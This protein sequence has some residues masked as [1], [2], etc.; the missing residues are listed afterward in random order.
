SR[1]ASSAGP[2]VPYPRPYSSSTVWIGVL[3]AATRPLT[4]PRSPTRTS[5]VASVPNALT[6]HRPAPAPVPSAALVHSAAAVVMPRT[7]PRSRMMAPA[8][9]KPIPEAT[10]AA[11]RIGSTFGPRSMSENP[12]APA[13][14]NTAAPPATSACVPQPAGLLRVSRSSPITAPKITAPRSRRATSSGP[15][16]G[17]HRRARARLCSSRTSMPSAAGGPRAATP[18]RSERWRVAR[19]ATPA[20]ERSFAHTPARRWAAVASSGEKAGRD[21]RFRR[22][23]HGALDR[24][25][26]QLGAAAKAWRQ[27]DTREVV[28]DGARQDVELR[29]D[30]AVGVAVRHEPQDV[31]LARHEKRSTTD[32]HAARDVRVLAQ[33]VAGERGSD[34][35][36]TAVDR[37]HCLSQLASADAL[38]P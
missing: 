29:S 15:T 19:R 12:Y 34:D 36:A 28:L 8:P 10:C 32:A 38:G 9:M 17:R 35:R 25:P 4:A 3:R 24:P 18:G 33:Q 20:A 6:H 1:T 14:V 13:I 7:E 22:S 2:S 27:A 31:L 23:G 16:K 5:S 11:T 37:H 21:G 26:R 30:L